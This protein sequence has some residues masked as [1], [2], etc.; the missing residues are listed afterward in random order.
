MNTK[1]SL[2]LLRKVR[3]GSGRCRVLFAG[4]GAIASLLGGC[5]HSPKSGPSIAAIR[6]NPNPVPAG[7]TASVTLSLRY[8]CEGMVFTWEAFPGSV[9]PSTN[10]EAATT[11]VAPS[12]ATPARI[13]VAINV[14]GKPVCSEEVLVQVVM[15]VGVNSNDSTLA[16]TTGTGRIHITVIPRYDEKGGPLKQGRIAGRVDGITA[17]NAS[18]YRVVIYSKTDDWWVQPT[19]AQPYTMLD[20]R[21]NFDEEIYLGSEYAVL[22]V[23]DS[24]TNALPRIPVLPRKGTEQMLDI[25]RVKEISAP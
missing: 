7:A 13:S 12:A 2:M 23:T 10:R 15:A 20:D 1:L 11:F 8:P 21:G 4:A 19:A 22:F 6:V 24:F 3:I 5:G 25:V 14:N 17:A 16:T 9:N 18:S